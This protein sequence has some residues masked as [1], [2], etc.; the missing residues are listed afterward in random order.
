[1]LVQR[2]VTI[3]NVPMQR[4]PVGGTIEVREIK[5]FC[6]H[7][8]DGHFWTVMHQPN[9]GIVVA[10]S[11]HGGVQS[12]FMHMSLGMALGVT[13]DGHPLMQRLTDSKLHVPLFTVPCASAERCSGRIVK[14]TSRL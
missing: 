5:P 6:S 10:G 8:D 9:D 7:L 3:V 14:T 12:V 4:T 2:I 13:T 1:M 11:L